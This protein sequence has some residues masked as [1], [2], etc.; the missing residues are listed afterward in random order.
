MRAGPRTSPAVGSR[1]LSLSLS[2]LLAF[3]VVAVTA[4]AEP[5]WRRHTI[6]HHSRGADG[7]R[8]ADLNGDGLPDVVTGWEQG[9]LVR[10]CLHPGLA[11]VTEL[12]PAVTVGRGEDVEDAVL[13]DL[14]RDG[15]LDVVSC[16]EGKKQAM[17]VHWGPAGELTDPA[18][19]ET[20]TIPASR[21]RCRW[22]FAAPLDVDANG[23]VDVVAGGKGDAAWLGWW[24][25]PEDAREVAAWQWHPLV[26]VGWVMS[27][28]AVDM[29]ADGLTDI[30]FSD[31]RGP[32]RGVSWLEHPGGAAA[33]DPS[34]W[35]RHRVGGAGSEVMFLDRADLDADG[36][37]D[38]VVAVQPHQL[39]ICQRLDADGLQWREVP[40]TLPETYGEAK[41]VAAADFDND[42]QLEL[43]F[44]T[45]HAEAPRQ[46]LGRMIRSSERLD[47]G[48]E[49][50]P[51]SGVDGV[52]HD[53]VVPIDLDGDGDLDVMTCEEVKN[54]GVIWYENPLKGS[55]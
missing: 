30:L 29:N 25:L 52:K 53:L 5:P 18:A 4:S 37:E 9:G 14:D 36:L 39:L 13:V 24:E 7:T 46:A 28:Q 2:L 38:V 17:L 49:V 1:R 27:V 3:A 22:M 26:K 33:A 16:C 47:G 43:V 10:V 40:L 31:R 34:A 8:L 35:K 55:R 54:L 11:A 15:V 6:D 21:D 12:W 44:S 23:Q 45:E 41:A 50:V 20:V 32:E 42:E 51:L 19:W 48:W